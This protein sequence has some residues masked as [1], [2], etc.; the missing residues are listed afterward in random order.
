[1]YFGI[2]GGIK[3]KRYSVVCFL[4]N[5]FGCLLLKVFVGNLFSV[6]C[7]VNISCMVFFLVEG[8]IGLLSNV[9]ENSSKGNGNGLN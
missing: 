8:L 3:E 2:F 6:K 7:F 9:A 4:G 5:I 1:M